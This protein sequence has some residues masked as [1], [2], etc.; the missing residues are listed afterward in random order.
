MAAVSVLTFSYCKKSNIIHV[1]LTAQYLIPL[2]S[3]SVFEFIQYL[4]VFILQ[5]FNVIYFLHV[6]EADNV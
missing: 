3:H 5:Y 1:L 4:Y 6:N 2:H